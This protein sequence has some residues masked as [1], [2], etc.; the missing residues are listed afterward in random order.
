MAVRE[1]ENSEPDITA[2]RFDYNFERGLART[3]CG[4]LD[5]DP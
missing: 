1:A 4:R 5:D 3:E 2:V